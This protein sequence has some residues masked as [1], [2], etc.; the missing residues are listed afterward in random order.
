MSELARTSSTVHAT[1]RGAVS[2]SSGMTTRI[3]LLAM[4]LHLSAP[5]AAPMTATDRF[6]VDGRAVAATLVAVSTTVIVGEPVML[7]LRVG[8]ETTDAMYIVS[9]PDRNGAPDS[10]TVTVTGPDG[11][12]P[13][14][15][16]DPL[17]GNGVT[18]ATTLPAKGT[19]VARLLL[20]EWV[21]IGKPGRYAITVDKVL[22]LGLGR[23]DG[24]DTKAT[25]H[26][27]HLTLA[28]EVGPGSPAQL[29]AVIDRLGTKMLAARDDV[30]GSLAGALASIHDARV[31]P[32]FVKAAALPDWGRQF[33]AIRALGDY[34][35]AASLAALERALALPGN[36]RISAAQSIAAHKTAAGMKILWALRGDPDESLRLEIVHALAQ[37]S[38][39]DVVAK[40]TEM[41]R[42]KSAMVSGEARRYLAE[43]KQ[44]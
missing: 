18:G 6:V 12:V 16:A 29:G 11:A 14:I 37:L 43:R 21:A 19:H 32:Y 5:R 25:K 17:A 15:P 2:E 7:E 38:P 22:R 1:A 33:V 9:S 10:F 35:T 3:G 24:W 8:N 40:L 41:S 20:S 26:P 23:G 13:A 31:V 34:S 30:G 36:G 42:D 44:P 39:P 4:L 28:I 27:T